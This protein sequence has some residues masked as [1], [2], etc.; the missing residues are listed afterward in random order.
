MAVR[1]AKQEELS[2]LDCMTLDAQFKTTIRDGLNCSPFEAE[3]V[4]QVVH[5]V[6]GAALGASD[7][8]VL[9]GQVTLVAVD[10]EEPAGKPVAECEK[11]TIR[12]MVHRGATDDRCLQEK[13]AA[14]FR[15]SRIP[16]LCQEAFSQGA[17]L[18]REKSMGQHQDVFLAFSQRGQSQLIFVESGEEILAKLP[19]FLQAPQIAMSGA[20]HPDVDPF[21]HGR[22]QWEHL[23]VLQDAEQLSLGLQRHV[24]DLVE[25]QGALM[26]SVDQPGLVAAGSSEGPSLVAEQLAL[27]EIG[28]NR[29]TVDRA[30]LAAPATVS[31]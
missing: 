17:L 21:R 4:L 20:H 23:L 13:K 27:Q 22:A 25:Q 24:A 11:R 15:R 2:R 29:R 18:T 5:E 14:A 3:A 12:L 10:A 8:G 31:V 19:S 6:Y 7:S 16:D 26:G 28:R 9:P 1:N 30:E